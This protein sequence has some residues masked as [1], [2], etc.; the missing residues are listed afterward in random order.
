[1][2]K[3]KEQIRWL[4]L[5][6]ITAGAIYVCWLM[7]VPFLRV[8]AWATVLVIVFHPVHKRIQAR[9]KSPTVSSLLSTIFAIVVI[10]IPLALITFA[11]FR[12]L[13]GASQYLQ[14][15]IGSFLDPNSSRTGKITAWLEQYINVDRAGLQTYLTD[16]LKSLTQYFAANSIGF[17]G[18]IVT[19]IAEFF[20]IIFTAYYLFR[21]NSR[22][23][24]AMSSALPLEGSQARRIFERTGE[25]IHA[26]VNG[27]VI[28][29]VLCGILGGLAFGVLGLPAPALW[30]AVIMF[31]SMI[32]MLG[33]FVVWV[34]A[35]I[36]L[37]ATGHWTQAILL[38][39][40]GG[41]VIASVDNFLRPKL[42]SEK[43]NLHELF[44]FFS[45]LGGLQVF[46]MLG[47]VLGPVVVAFTLSLLDALRQ[48]DR[49]AEVTRLEP[50]L[51]EKQAELSNAS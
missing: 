45:A 5:L 41:L 14:N 34:P 19:A 18:N 32:P 20:F 46:G 50:T 28:I 27:I 30:G 40:W 49:P 51:V 44:V 6:G 13:S 9:G 1:M 17:A 23:R 25:V 39:V 4:A 11:I 42:V 22:I 2:S 15:N 36:Y 26:S 24:A 16:R 10:L 12:E 33:S 8:L 38:A 3:R 48:V 31:F 35:A 37:A 47:I 7:L 29:S 43:V 21:D